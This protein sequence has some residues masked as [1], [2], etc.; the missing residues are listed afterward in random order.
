ML[1]FTSVG[2]NANHSFF[3]NETVA[4]DDEYDDKS[5]KLTQ[6]NNNIRHNRE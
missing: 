4:D 2:E 3:V 5:D 6:E 1:I